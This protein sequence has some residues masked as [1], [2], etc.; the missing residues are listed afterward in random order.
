MVVFLTSSPT[1]PL[2]GSRKVVGLD[3]KNRFVENLRK[4]WKKDAKNLMI[5]ATPDAYEQ[6][7]EMISF[8]EN[9]VKQDGFRCQP[10][11]VWD[12]RTK[13]FSKEKLHSYDVI[14]L[15][16]GHVPTQNRFFE[17]ISLREKIEGFR[18]IIIGIS[19]GTMNAADVVYAQPE[20]EGEAVDP[21]FQRFL[22]GIGLTKMQILPHYQ[23]VRDWY[24]DGQR[25]YEDI[26]YNDS[27]GHEFLVL[28][29]GSYLMS[30]DGKEEVYGNAYVISDGQICKIKEDEM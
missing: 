11:E 2:D 10:F 7:D 26:T 27:Y 14:W 3:K 1:G 16:G 20:H 21:D 25:L 6:N 5:T 22:K 24:L 18:G 19:A 4:Y 30:R 13:D 17:E 29:D 15:G 28:E 12:W 8:F 23:M 9:A